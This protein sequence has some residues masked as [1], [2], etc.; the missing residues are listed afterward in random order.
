MST[1]RL[2]E[3]AK[4]QKTGIVRSLKDEFNTD[5]V[6]Q[7]KHIIIKYSTAIQCNTKNER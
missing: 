5:F 6:G 3:T 2:Q 7:K 4:R 1:Y